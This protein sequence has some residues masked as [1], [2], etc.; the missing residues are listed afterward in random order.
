VGVRLARAHD[1]AATNVVA[2]DV[3]GIDIFQ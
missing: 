2:A 3:F 1:S